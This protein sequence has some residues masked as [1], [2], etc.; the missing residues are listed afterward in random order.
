MTKATEK[1]DRKETFNL[2]LKER[3]DAN[4]DALNDHSD[5]YWEDVCE[6]LN[7][8]PIK[9]KIPISVER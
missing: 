7:I 8:V 3:S 6:R 4:F 2:I 1:I 9:E 5:T